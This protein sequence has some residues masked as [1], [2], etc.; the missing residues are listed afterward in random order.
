M[1]NFERRYEVAQAFSPS[2][3][4]DKASLFAGRIQQITTIIIAVAQKG[5]HAIIFGERGVGKTSLANVVHDFVTGQG[6][7][8]VL[9]AKVNCDA[10][11]TYPKLWRNILRQITVFRKHRAIGFHEAQNSNGRAR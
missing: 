3:P 5:K 7:I 4:I 1:G 2:A 6:N 10:T 8:E 9:I 11:I